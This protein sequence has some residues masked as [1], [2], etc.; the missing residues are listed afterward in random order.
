MTEHLHILVYTR[1]LSGIS[2]Q[3]LDAPAS[4]KGHKVSPE[5]AQCHFL[6]HCCHWGPSVSFLSSLFLCSGTSEQL[7]PAWCPLV[8]CYIR[9]QS[10]IMQLNA[11]ACLGGGVWPWDPG[12]SFV[13]PFLF[14]YPRIDAEC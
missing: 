3:D 1:M 12:A 11:C 10:N 2:T 4:S 5:K 6:V 14:H 8:L 13:S 7:P 9:M